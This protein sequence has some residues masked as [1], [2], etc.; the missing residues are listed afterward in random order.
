MTTSLNINFYFSNLYG[1]IFLSIYELF[2]MLIPFILAT[3]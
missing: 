2:T 3:K 1:N